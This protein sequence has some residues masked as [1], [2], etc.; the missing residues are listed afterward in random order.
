MRSVSRERQVVFLIAAAPVGADITGAPVQ[1]GFCARLLGFVLDRSNHMS[2]SDRGLDAAEHRRSSAAR[3]H[4]AQLDALR[5][6]AVAGVLYFHF[7]QKSVAPGLPWGSLGVQLFFVLSGFLITDILLGL[8]DR[9]DRPPGRLHRLRQFYIRRSL[10]I[11]PLAYFVIIGTAV[12]NVPAM[13]DTLPWN[14]TYTSNIYFSSRGAWNGVASHLWSLA[15]EEQFYLLWPWLML[16]LPGR[17]LLPA[18]V[19]TILIAP[20][21]LTGGILVGLNPVA[22]VALTPACLDKLG[23][24]AL[25]AFLRYKRPSQFQK[26]AY[27]P[28][29]RWAG[30]VALPIL[31]ALIW[32]AHRHWLWAPISS[33]AVSIFFAWFV[34][35]AA[36]GFDGVWG[37][38]LETR[39][40]AYC[41]RI[42]YGIYVYHNFMFIAVPWLLRRYAMPYP[43]HRVTEFAMYV[44]A[45]FVVAACS[46]VF[47]EQPVNNFRQRFGYW[48][49]PGATR[50]FATTAA[51]TSR[52][53][54]DVADPTPAS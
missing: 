22:L 48:S 12:L 25:L 26:L 35:R 16:F 19:G 30:V 29:Y 43:Q 17:Y 31:I 45:T 39:P 15:V 21:Y 1:K 38:L 50:L 34:H 23:M 10:R 9:D 2:N 37:W 44:C 51:R 5:A 46:W 41:G 6:I 40:F 47:F 52:R 20:L 24:G 13:R 18:I 54:D 3:G 8:R 42:S 49:V 53:R 33:L 32:P 11:V 14:L 36:S 4:M 28:A 7:Y 27:Q